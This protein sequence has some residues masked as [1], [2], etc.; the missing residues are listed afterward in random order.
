MKRRTG[1]SRRAALLRWDNNLVS[2]FWAKVKKSPGCWVWTGSRLAT[3]YG[4]LKARGKHYGAHRMA[5]E[6]TFWAVPSGMCVLHRCDNP[7]CVRPDHLF[8]GSNRDNVADKVAKGRQARGDTHGSR[9]R[10]DRVPRGE[11]NGAHLHPE[12]R[13]RGE[14]VNTSRLTR[15]QVLEIRALVQSR[16]ATQRAIAERLGVN[17]MTISRAVAGTSWGWI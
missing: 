5:Y 8:L 3:G 1:N 2:R 16:N 10:P 6:L 7:P 4:R 17:R 12:T 13:P 9:T 11:R 15:K 14:R